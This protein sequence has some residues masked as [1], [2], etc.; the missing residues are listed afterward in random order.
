MNIAHKNCEPDPFILYYFA[1]WVLP[2]KDPSHEPWRHVS[3][4]H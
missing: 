3:E 1:V 4:E 2:D